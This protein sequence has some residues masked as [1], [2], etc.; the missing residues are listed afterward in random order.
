MQDD[1]D[2]WMTKYVARAILTLFSGFALWWACTTHTNT[3]QEVFGTKN[4]TI[5]ALLAWAMLITAAIMVV[6][7][8]LFW[9]IKN[10]F[11]ED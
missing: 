1:L 9:A 8:I 4:P 11:K 6:L 7:G 10:A 5:I 3:V 2:K